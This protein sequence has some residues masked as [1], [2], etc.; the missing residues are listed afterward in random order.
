VARRRGQLLQR[1]H[2]LRRVALAQFGALDALGV[3]DQSSQFGIGARR[4]RH[5]SQL[6]RGMKRH[7]RAGGPS[8]AAVGEQRA[9]PMVREHPLDEV[10]AQI[11][12]VQPTLLFDR[13]I[14]QAADQRL[15]EQ[16]APIA[17]RHPRASIDAHPFHPATRRILLQHVAR[18][19]F[20]LQRCRAAPGIRIHRFGQVGAAFVRDHPRRAALPAD[21]PQALAR[22]GEAD[23]DLGAD[24]DELDEAAERAGQEIAALVAA[25][26]AHLL[27]QQTGGNANPD[28]T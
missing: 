26:E 15:G 13:Q 20:A 22:D 14:G 9:Q 10:L 18:E 7:Q 12:I 16:A 24:R 28:R 5:Q 19:I 6:V 23:I 4:V 1:R 11:R 27:P 2:E 21:Q 17:H 8:G 3:R 25:V